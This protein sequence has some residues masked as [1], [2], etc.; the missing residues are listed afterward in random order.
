MKNKKTPDIWAQ[1]GEK[2]AVADCGCYIE[3]RPDGPAF[4]RCAGCSA[5]VKAKA[6]GWD[7]PDTEAIRRGAMLADVLYLKKIRGGDDAGRYRTRWGTKSALGLYLTLKR[8]T[9][10]DFP[11]EA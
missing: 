10:G 9:E 2:K 5:A 3:N 8:I 11:K 7:I 6:E 1:A 4:Y